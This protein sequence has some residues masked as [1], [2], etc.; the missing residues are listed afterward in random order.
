M[1]TIAV[2]NQKGGTGKTTTA[3]NLGAILAGLGLRVLLLDLD[4]QSSLTAACG[5][6]ADDVAGRSLADVLGGA[7]AGRLSLAEVVRDLGGGL[8]LAPADIALAG[9]ELGLTARLGRESVLRRALA[10]IAGGFDLALLDCPPS[11]GLL[12][13]AGLVAA[14][15]VIIPTQPQA[16]DLRGVAL[17]VDTLRTVQSELNPALEVLGVVVTFYDSR[18]NHH[19]Q[20]LEYIQAGGLPILGS[21][22][23][24]VRVAESAGAGQPMT[25]F[26]PNNPQTEAYKSLAEKVQLWL[27]R[28]TTGKTP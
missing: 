16:A 8:S 24:S 3:H 9:C 26:A 7:Q 28:K 23:R 22:G 11:L 25:T 15:A 14:D 5:V 13:V 17:F 12:T 10:P 27:K 1:I 6:A 4:P 2:S 19:R 18:L 21:V 20:A